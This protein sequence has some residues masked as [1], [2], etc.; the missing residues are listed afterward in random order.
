LSSRRPRGDAPRGGDVHV[1]AGERA[2]GE[3]VDAAAKRVKKILVDPKRRGSEVIV[4]ARALG[5]A[6]VDADARALAQASVDGPA[7]GIVAIAAPPREHALDELVEAALARPRGRLVAL[8]GVEDPHNLGAI[9]R[10]A[11]FFGAAGVF[12]PKD[13][14]APLSPAA[15]RASAGASERLPV[16]KV[17]NLARALAD[18]KDAGL[19]IVGTVAEG[20]MSLADAVNDDRLPEHLVIVMGS[21][22]DGLRRLTRDRCDYLVTIER[23]GA[24]ASLNVSAAA[25]VVLAALR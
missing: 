16:G 25:A 21:E 20:G 10:S 6:I 12:W 13:G 3:L 11:E 23:T 5:I 4:R 24:I 2:V 14:S 15:V 1:V 18:C 9:I 22:H 19:W 17:G 7:K 8:D